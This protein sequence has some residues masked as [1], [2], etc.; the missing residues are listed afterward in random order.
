MGGSPTPTGDPACSGRESE[1]EQSGPARGREEPQSGLPGDVSRAAGAP[2]SFLSPPTSRAPA[3]SGAYRHISGSCP[4]AH[5]S[6]GARRGK[7]PSSFSRRLQQQSP[8]QPAA[9]PARHG[10]TAPRAEVGGRDRL[11]PTGHRGHSRPSAA[12]AQER[13]RPGAEEPRTRGTAG[14]DR[15]K[16][17]RERGHGFSHLPRPGGRDLHPDEP[18]ADP[19]GGCWM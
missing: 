2:P 5:R 7:E 19:S 12:A 6:P 13:C 18:T 8:A 10:P 4:L 9:H 15:G 16:Q 11:S 1:W 3:G 14:L 17:P